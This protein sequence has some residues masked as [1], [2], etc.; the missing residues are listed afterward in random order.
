MKKITL[1]FLIVSLLFAGIP[2][3]ADAES[4][5]ISVPQPI[6]DFIQSLGDINIDNVDNRLSNNFSLDKSVIAQKLSGLG[7]QDIWDGANDWMQ[8][9]IGISVSQIVR[10]IGNFIV[11]SLDLMIKLIKGGLDELGG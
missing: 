5:E 2:F 6:G 10:V 3:I 1:S 9:T 7:I 8:N 4:I 11:W